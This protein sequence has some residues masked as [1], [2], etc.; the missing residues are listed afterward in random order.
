MDEYRP[1]FVIYPLW[2]TNLKSCLDAPFLMIELHN[3][4]GLQFDI[5]YAKHEFLFSDAVECFKKQIM[6]PMNGNV[7][8]KILIK[9]I[10]FC[11][12]SDILIKVNPVRQAL[13]S[14]LKFYSSLY[15]GGKP[16][17]ILRQIVAL[18]KKWDMSFFESQLGTFD[19]WLQILSDEISHRDTFINQI[20][21]NK[22]NPKTKEMYNSELLA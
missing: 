9:L 6:I 8:L 15:A 5:P 3:K 21:A 20:E 7:T 17:K 4:K 16:E 11:F 2:K 19:L 13:L 12:D 22:Q 10:D 1:Y 14:T 18:S